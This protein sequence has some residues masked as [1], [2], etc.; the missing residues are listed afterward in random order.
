MFEFVYLTER[1]YIT[2]TFDS[3]ED[4]EFRADWRQ[5]DIISVNEVTTEE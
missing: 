3:I 2:R 1:G 5:W 4:G